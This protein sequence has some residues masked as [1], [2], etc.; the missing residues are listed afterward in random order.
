MGFLLLSIFVGFVATLGMTSLLW[1]ADRSGWANANMVRALG[2]TITRSFETSLLPGII[3]QFTAGFVFAMI[4][5]CYTNGSDKRFLSS[6]AGRGFP[7]LSPRI[8]V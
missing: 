2:S 4:Y 5:I 7:R 1:I 8:R 6:S 3:V